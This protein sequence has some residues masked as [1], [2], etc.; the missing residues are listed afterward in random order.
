MHMGDASCIGC[1]LQDSTSSGAL[2]RYLQVL[3]GMQV[4]SST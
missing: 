4:A 2:H 3:R 1:C